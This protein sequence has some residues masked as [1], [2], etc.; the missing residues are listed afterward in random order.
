MIK[1]VFA[2]GPRLQTMNRRVQPFFHKGTIEMQLHISSS[3]KFFKDHLIH[4]AASIDQCRRQNGKAAALFA[5]ASRTKEL[6][7]FQ[8]GL[9]FYAT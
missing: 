6:L 1:Q 3:L 5:V 4:L 9:C 7:G 2:T 8:E